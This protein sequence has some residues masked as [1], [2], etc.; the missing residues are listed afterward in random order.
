ML[1]AI[2]PSQTRRIRRAVRRRI[3]ICYA[4]VLKPAAGLRTDRCA[5]IVSESFPHCACFAGRAKA[6]HLIILNRMAVL[7]QNDFCFFGIVNSSQP[8]GD[9]CRAR[10]VEG[11]VTIETIYG[12]DLLPIV[13]VRKSQRLDVALSHVDVVVTHDLAEAVTGA[14]ENKIITAVRD[15]FLLAAERYI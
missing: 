13:D 4:K 7:V 6:G 15:P 11:V 3:P 10:R 1:W 5:P 2:K 9:V 14:I 12:E 8:I